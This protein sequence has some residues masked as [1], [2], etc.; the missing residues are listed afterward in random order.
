MV[1]QHGGVYRSGA[2]LD[3]GVRVAIALDIQTNHYRY[4]EIAWKR[5]VSLGM[6]SKVA[7]ILQAER[8]L[9][10]LARGGAN[11][12][13]YPAILQLLA[14]LAAAFPISWL[15]DYAEALTAEL[16]SSDDEHISLSTVHRAMQRLGISRKKIQTVA[17]EKLTEA[18]MNYYGRFIAFMWPMSA[19]RIHFM[20]ESHYNRLDL[21]ATYG[22]SPRGD[23]IVVTQYWGRGPTF[24]FLSLLLI[25]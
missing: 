7:A 12:T 25:P 24:A 13:K 19:H 5:R 8:S 23:P 4:R 22:Y 10:V 9:A 3:E 2:P 15:A 14:A 21:N 16:A 1:N 18:N 11:N 17:K 6:V 20:D